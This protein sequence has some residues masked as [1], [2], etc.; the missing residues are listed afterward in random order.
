MTATTKNVFRIEEEC[1]ICHEL[2]GNVIEHNDKSNSHL[3]R[4]VTMQSMCKDCFKE[5]EELKETLVVHSPSAGG[6]FKCMIVDEKLVTKLAYITKPEL[7][8]KTRIVLVEEDL[9]RKLKDNQKK[10]NKKARK[11]AAK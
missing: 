2:T 5:R 4:G 1:P 3:K 10:V 7:F 8:E 11:I 9:F 6:D